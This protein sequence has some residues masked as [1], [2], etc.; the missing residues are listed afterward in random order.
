MEDNFRYIIHF[1]NRDKTRLTYKDACIFL[2]LKSLEKLFFYS[3]F[4]VFCEHYFFV[5][6]NTY[7]IILYGFMPHTYYVRIFSS[8]HSILILLILYFDTNMTNIVSK[9]QEKINTARSVSVP[10][11]RS[12]LIRFY[13]PYLLRTYLFFRTYYFN[14]TCR[15]IRYKHD[16]YCIKI[17]RKNK[18]CQI[19]FC[20]F[21]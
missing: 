7:I 17:S 16:K 3:F 12:N 14:F 6:K 4:I 20:P 2:Q 19:S 1:P 13:A 15:I 8:V 21:P 5:S 18:H 11:R 10:F 9:Y